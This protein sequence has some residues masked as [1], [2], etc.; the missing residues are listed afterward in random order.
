MK[1]EINE[2][3]SASNV[4]KHSIRKKDAEQLMRLERLL[5]VEKWPKKAGKADYMRFL[6]GE[7]LTRAEADRA[8]CYE[9]VAGED[10]QPCIVYTCPS[11]DYCQW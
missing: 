3:G 10:T 2:L 8:T 5:E 11:F 4:P 7:K 6:R 9:C 1:E